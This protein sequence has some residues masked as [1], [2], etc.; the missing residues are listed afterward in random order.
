M[1]AIKPMLDVQIKAAILEEEE[2]LK[3]C[4]TD[5]INMRKNIDKTKVKLELALK[6][7]E[8][9]DLKG[10]NGGSEN[11]IVSWAIEDNEALLYQLERHLVLAEKKLQARLNINQE[12]DASRIEIEVATDR[13]IE[14][15]RMMAQGFVDYT[16][17]DI[18]IKIKHERIKSQA[19]HNL[20]GISSSNS[21]KDKMK[22]DAEKENDRL[23]KEKQLSIKM[24]NNEDFQ[25][26]LR[27]LNYLITCYNDEIEIL[28]TD[29][30]ELPVLRNN[31]CKL[32]DQY[33]KKIENGTKVKKKG[34]VGFYKFSES[35]LGRVLINERG[36]VA[37]EF[38]A[39][40]EILT[41]KDFDDRPSWGGAPPFFI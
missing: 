26:S 14:A 27:D 5:I 8:E 16:I 36:V 18:L 38:R 4:E 3:K 40:T 39:R 30:F 13:L 12:D 17:T 21:K 19:N 25:D 2:D 1:E 15:S 35:S 6:Q 34:D 9:R 10:M 11:N 41:F 33:E 28:H 7:K 22:E 32:F 37:P 31:V 23:E 24:D 29:Y 20:G